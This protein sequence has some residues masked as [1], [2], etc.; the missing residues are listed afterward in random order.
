MRSFEFDIALSALKTESLYQGRARYLLVESEQGLKL[1]L[2]AINFREYV[3][4][5][6]I[7]G[8]FRVS[9][10]AHN[11]ILALQKI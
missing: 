5:R 11:K 8:R 3:T 10:D 7:N 9:I 1:Q 4:D 6:G 2:P